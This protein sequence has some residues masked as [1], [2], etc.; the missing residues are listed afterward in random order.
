ML[1]LE[2]VYYPIELRICLLPDC[3]KE[4]ITPLDCY[5]TSLDCYTV[6]LLCCWFDN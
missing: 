2:C 4:Y 6:E 3:F 5:I 1:L